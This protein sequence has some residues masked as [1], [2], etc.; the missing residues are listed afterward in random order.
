MKYEICA[1]AQGAVWALGTA[2]TYSTM[3]YVTHQPSSRHIPSA[4]LLFSFILHLIGDAPEGA[5]S[6]SWPGD[7]Q[8]LSRAT[9]GPS[10]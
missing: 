1:T 4:P 6:T 9:A 8:K 10:T 3:P 7:T 2:A 5:T